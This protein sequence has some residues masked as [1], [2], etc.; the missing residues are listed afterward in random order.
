MRISL[1]NFT[2]L[3]SLLASYVLHCLNSTWGPSPPQEVSHGPDQGH[4][5]DQG[6]GMIYLVFMVCLFSFF[7]FGIMLSYIRSRKVEGSHDPYHQYI[8]R[9]W[10][11]C[12]A[13]CHPKIL[14]VCGACYVSEGGEGLRFM[15]PGGSLLPPGRRK[16]A[17]QLAH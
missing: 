7:T 4:G 5:W 17:N 10:S 14:H 9:D 15:I 1:G 3:P 12:V 6:Q 16:P 13:H 11:P 2:K 8:A